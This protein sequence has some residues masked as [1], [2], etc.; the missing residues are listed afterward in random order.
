M[1]NLPNK[2]HELLECG[3]RS[4]FLG[5]LKRHQ[6]QALYSM[7]KGDFIL[8]FYHLHYYP[9]VLMLDD[10]EELKK[11]NEKFENDSK[12]LL[13]DSNIST[14]SPLTLE[15]KSHLRYFKKYRDMLKNAGL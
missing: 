15:P 8:A 14:I 4:N 1:K 5:D 9:S 11:I 7:Q 6:L 2:L 10:E 13:K 12:K 3:I